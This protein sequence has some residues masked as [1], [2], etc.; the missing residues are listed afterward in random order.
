MTKQELQR[1]LGQN[2]RKARMEQNLT[3]E[4]LA[5]KVGI[6]TTFYSNLECGNKMTSIVTLRK[7][8]DTLCVSTDSLLYCEEPGEKL[9]NINMLLSSQST[10]NIA[11]IEKLIRLCISSLPA[12]ENRKE[13][14]WDQNECGAK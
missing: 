11:F 1:I 9:K 4:Q 5:E 6:S 3:I 8:A 14:V 10:E 12:A 2:L 7:L 13:G